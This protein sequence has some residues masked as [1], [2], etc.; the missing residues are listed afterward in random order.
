MSDAASAIDTRKTGKRALL[1]EFWSYFSENKGAVVGL[2]VFVFVVLLAVFADVVAPHLPQEQ[3][4]DA[5]LTPPFWQDGADP[6]FLLGTDAVGRD[7]LSR[8]IYGSRYSL[9]IGVIVVTISLLLGVTIGL[10][11]GFFR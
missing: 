11:T 10:L 8:L 9:F 5:F 6:R 4:R 3:Y 1:A 2:G 7:I